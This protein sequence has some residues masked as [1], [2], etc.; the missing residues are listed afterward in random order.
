LI[1]G[2]FMSRTRKGS[3]PPP[4]SPP[5]QLVIPHEDAAERI[6]NQI[7]KGTELSSFS[8]GSEVDFKQAEKEYKLWSD[9]NRELLA[10]IFSSDEISTEYSH[11]GVA[12]VAFLGTPSLGEQIERFHQRL[13]VKIQS[14][15]SILGR[16]D[17]IPTSSQVEDRSPSAPSS[18]QVINTRK[19]FV[20]H[21][22]DDAA[23]AN[24]EVFLFEIGLEPIVLHRQAEV[25]Y[26]S[27]ADNSIGPKTR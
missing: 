1:E 20:V 12:P 2:N 6:E 10:R 9:Y 23:K 21:G 25:V 15:Q 18:G 17:L 11:A 19:A 3:T 14:L 4:V 8:I 16:L 24:L 26:L 5:V 27:A 7:V 22:H 13:D